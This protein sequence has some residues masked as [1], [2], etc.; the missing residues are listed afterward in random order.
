MRGGVRAWEGREEGGEGAWVVV[1]G[2]GGVSGG[3]GWMELLFVGRSN[4]PVYLRDGSAQTFV[5][6]ATLR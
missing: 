1:G 4:M 6:A 3:V 2:G 5:R